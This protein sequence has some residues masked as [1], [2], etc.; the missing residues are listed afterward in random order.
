MLCCVVLCCHHH[1]HHHQENH[2]SQPEPDGRLNPVQTYQRSPKYRN[3][4]ITR[5]PI[6]SNANPM[7]LHTLPISHENE[8]YHKHSSQG[9]KQISNQMQLQDV[10][11]SQVRM[12]RFCFRG[13]NTKTNQN[14]PGIRF[15]QMPQVVLTNAEV[16]LL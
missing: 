14:I 10:P 4:S 6:P 11:T 16:G 15:L 1:H 7:A 13:Y 12:V 2:L 9:L 3:K 8:L 5:P